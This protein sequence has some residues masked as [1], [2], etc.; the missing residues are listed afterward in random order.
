MET[1]HWILKKGLACRKA[2]GS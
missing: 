1:F 2:K